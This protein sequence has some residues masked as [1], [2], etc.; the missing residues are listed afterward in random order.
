MFVQYLTKLTDE[1]QKYCINDSLSL[2]PGYFTSNVA[3]NAK[4]VPDQHHRIVYETP[5]S[6]NGKFQQFQL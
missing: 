3:E 2:Q 1:D 5:A 4:F 6:Q